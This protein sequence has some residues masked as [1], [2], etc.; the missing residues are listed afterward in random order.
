MYCRYVYTHKHT[1]AR[2][3]TMNVYWFSFH[4]TFIFRGSCVI[5]DS[6]LDYSCGKLH[7]YVTAFNDCYSAVYNVHRATTFKN[8]IIIII[9]R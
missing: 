6:T 1:H 8:D 5:F 7:R 2:T 4:L 9:M 3:H